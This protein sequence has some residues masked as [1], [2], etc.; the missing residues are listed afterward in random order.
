MTAF[1]F[2]TL[3]WFYIRVLCTLHGRHRRERGTV[4]RKEFN[5][6]EQR[7][8]WKADCRSGCQISRRFITVF[9]LA[10][11]WTFY[12]GRRIHSISLHRISFGFILILSLYLNV[13]SPKWFL[14]FGFSY[15]NFV[16]LFPKYILIEVKFDISEC[17]V[18]IITRISVCVSTWSSMPGSHLTGAVIVA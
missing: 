6:V 5:S 4:P 9:R 7:P 14:P 13:S 12:W 3:P 16:W 15:Q 10:R 1:S 18:I 17:N 2:V 8:S 11:H